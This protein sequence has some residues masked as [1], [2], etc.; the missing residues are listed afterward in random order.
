MNRPFVKPLRERNQVVVAIW[1]TVLAAAVVLLA[2]NLSSLPFVS[3]TDTYYANFVNTEG[4]KT[5]DDVRVEGITVGSVDSIAVQGDHV[6]VGFDVQSGLHLGGA[7]GA[8]IEVATVLGNL[9]LQVESA[10]PGRLAPDSTIPVA[11]TVV[12]YSLLEAFNAFGKFSQQTDIP[13]LQESLQTLAT[14]ISGIAPTDVKAALKGLANVSTTLASKQ[15]EVS[16]VLQAADAIVGTLN[17]NSGALVGLLVQGDE[18]LKLVEQRHTLI[19]QLLQDTAQLGTQLKVLM[20]RNGAQLHSLLTD[21]DTVTA[22]LVKEKQ[23]L[24]NAIIYLGQFGENIT[25][26]T[27]AGPWLDLLTPTVVV[28]DNQIKGCGTNPA[29]DKKPCSP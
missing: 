15:Q 8:S 24:Q 9:F 20:D 5:G 3:S 10:G 4:L 26:V 12:P 7:S 14:T 19:D 21:L 16:E 29:A 17:K 23:Q 28:P 18:F 1:G 22:T 2:M 25:N 13:K 27:G 11:R 6:H